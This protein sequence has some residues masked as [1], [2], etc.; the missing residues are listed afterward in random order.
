M[1]QRRKSFTRHFFAVIFV[2]VL[3][4]AFGG[5]ANGAEAIRLQ[6]D[7]TNIDVQKTRFELC[8]ATECRMIDVS[9]NTSFKDVNGKVSEFANLVVGDYATVIGRVRGEENGD[10]TGTFNNDVLHQTA[11]NA[12][13]V[14]IGI[15][16]QITIASGTLSNLDTANRT[17]DVTS[18]DPVTRELKITPVAVPLDAEILLVDST[19]G[20]TPILITDLLAFQQVEV[21]GQYSAT[22]ILVAQTVL[23]TAL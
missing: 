12:D 18:V 9:K 20:T 6:G 19:G 4:A 16:V 17:F 2:G 8:S 10:G 11:V 3:M 21:H 1:V 22:G 23:A 15:K 14:D 13:L 5:V 7:V